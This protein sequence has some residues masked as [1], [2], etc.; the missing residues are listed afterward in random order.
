M[1]R[2]P[3]TDCE[4]KIASAYRRLGASTVEHDVELAGHQVD[5]F[6]E[7]ELTDGS[8]HRIAVESKDYA[9]PVGV[10]I[11]REF[12]QIVARLRRLG[13]IDQ[14]VLVS[15]S[16][17]SRPA[18]NA[19]DREPHLR[20]LE[21]ADL[22]TMATRPVEETP[23]SQV[24]E[25]PS[26]EG[27]DPITTPSS[28]GRTPHLAQRVRVDPWGSDPAHLLLQLRERL[29]G[30]EEPSPH[31]RAAVLLGRLNRLEEAS[32]N[33]LRGDQLLTC[34]PPH[35]RTLFGAFLSVKQGQ[36][37]E[38]IRDLR[39]YLRWR[40]IPQRDEAI[41]NDLLGQ[42]LRRKGDL[43][44][45]RDAFACALEAKGALGDVDGLGITLGNLGRLELYSAR[46]KQAVTLLE[47]N[48]ETL[49]TQP[50]PSLGLVRNNLAEAYLCDGQID[51]AR[52]NVR[53][54]IEAAESS[55]VDCGFAQALLVEI[56]L[57]ERRPNPASEALGSARSHFEDAAF[58]DGVIL[59]EEL[60]G[61]LATAAGWTLTAERRFSNF[62]EVL[63]ERQDPLFHS[64]RLRRRAHVAA[65]CG[66][67]GL[68]RRALEQARQISRANDLP[69][70]ADL[71][72]EGESLVRVATGQ[73]PE[74]GTAHW[75]MHWRTRLARPLAR[76][77]PQSSEDPLTLFAFVE[78]LTDLCL[79]VS[80]ANLEAHGR[81]WKPSQRMSLGA[82]VGALRKNLTV[83]S[84]VGSGL[85]AAG[86]SSLLDDLERFVQIRNQLVH[87]L[88]AI[89]ER[90][91]MKEAT[92]IFGRLLRHSVHVLE[93]KLD[94]TSSG[95]VL[96][97]QGTTATLPP[98]GK[99]F[100]SLNNGSRLDLSSWLRLIEGKLARRSLESGSVWLLEDGSLLGTD[101]PGA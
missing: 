70:V 55:V 50:T 100:L 58:G 73:E 38:A 60:E 51:S 80:A 3:G 13:E 59:L 11:I 56:E 77:L 68:L 63:R 89:P 29:G 8:L 21:T 35:E 15:T 42:V 27:H 53:S 48:L 34:E 2:K 83:L 1:S 36:Y 28:G 44:G 14:G 5:V 49:A 64:Y 82:K 67:D 45:A 78:R 57:T 85:F 96:S 46:F 62:D 20:L 32:E 75:A 97:L 16:G 7:M 84:N 40:G 71:I 25:E 94:D 95:D 52:E 26:S 98:S 19:A 18:R 17:F 65:A 31:W 43:A 87:P 47:R 91:G 54:V 79:L 81:E 33:L 90:D 88:D 76:E 99:I 30:I 69:I 22:N 39:E 92:T 72:E 101:V 4:R 37:A 10:A 61:F 74:P 66:D 24:G 93:L 6:V 86:V 12:S 23:G 9:K 41:A